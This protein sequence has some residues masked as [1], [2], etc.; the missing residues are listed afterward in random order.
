MSDVSNSGDSRSYHILG[1]QGQK[2]PQ[3]AV[4]I[5]YGVDKRFTR[6]LCTSIASVTKNTDL[7]VVAHVFSNAFGSM[8]APLQQLADQL[9]ITILLHPVD[10]EQF[11]GWATEGW[12]FAIYQR[13]V[14][15]PVLAQFTSRFV[16]LDADVLCTGDIAP[17]FG[18][19]LHGNIAAAV[20]DPDKSGHAFD[21]SSYSCARYFNSGVLLIDAMAWNNNAITNSLYNLL[22]AKSHEFRS[23]DQ[24]ALNVVLD[25]RIEILAPD[26]NYPA[27][28]NGH[29]I[30][31]DYK[32]ANPVVHPVL[33][34]FMGGDK[35]WVEGVE[36]DGPDVEQYL[37]YEQFT[38]F[39]EVARQRPQTRRE[40]KVCA[41]Y[42]L[43][44]KKYGAGLYWFF[45]YLT[46][47]YIRK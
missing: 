3:N 17:L 12:S 39:K 1:M 41:R 6:A 42:M 28:T 33:K 38:P 27:D 21:K 18:L 10:A 25:G 11:A 4:H 23:Y 37:Y 44:R 47:K 7:T 40:A 36:G 46:M 2:L 32:R 45:N 16:Y 26:Y 14:M 5:A 20:E 24:D 43:K 31:K 29:T 8:F 35:P 19:D 30:V 9:H 22:A 15:A 34:H 13:L